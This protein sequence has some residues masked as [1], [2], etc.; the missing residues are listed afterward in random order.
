MFEHLQMHAIDDG[1]INGPTQELELPDEMV[2][3]NPFIQLPSEDL[4]GWN[5]AVGEEEG[6]ATFIPADAVSISEDCDITEVLAAASMSEGRSYGQPPS[7][8]EES[9]GSG[10]RS[11]Q[12]HF[13]ANSVCPFCSTQATRPAVICDGCGVMLTLSDLD[14]LLVHQVPDPDKLAAAI[15]DIESRRS[16][17][18][19]SADDLSNLAIGYL[20]LHDLNLAMACL[21]QASGFKPNDVLI[22]G[23]INTLAIRIDEME[24]HGEARPAVKGRSILVVDD[25]A[26]V[27]KLISGK[28]E[29]CGH[30]VICVGDG[31]EAL[32]AVERRTPDLILL[33]ISMPKM[34][35][36]QTCRALRN[37][38]K[39]AS[40]PV[41]MISG[42]DGFF[43]KVRGKRAGTTD[44]ITKPFGPETLMKAL[45][46]YLNPGEVPIH[47]E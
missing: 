1:H 15:E 25:S 31:S 23:Q 26:T 24:R 8:D 37:N 10:S 20:N 14:A 17:D 40:V 7:Y 11:G 29:K 3:S 47:A 2:H 39:T 4:S 30:N 33:D 6:S 9:G 22:S 13:D 16:T 38:P 34:D 18:D 5:S 43:D 42:K 35:G 27:R 28:L 36:Y 46:Q 41:I 12:W 19:F 45:D 32:E 21:R 44:Y